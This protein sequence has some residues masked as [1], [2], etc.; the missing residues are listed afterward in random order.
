M[1][2][3]IAIIG[4]GGHGKVA[5]DTAEA[6]GYTE[7]VFL[8]QK[9]GERSRNGHWPIIGL[10][11]LSKDRTCFL[12]IGNNSTRERLCKELDFATLPS[13]V[14][15]TAIVSRYAKLERGVL[16]VAGSVINVDVFIGECSIINT[17]AT[18]DHDC[19][20]GAFVHI[21]PGANIAGGVSVGDRSWI[22]A[23]AVVKENIKIGADALVGAGAVVINDVPDGS[24]VVGNPAKQRIGSK[25]C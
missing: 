14:H 13:L 1:V 11:E 6:A 5:A 9:Y 17:S 16:L 21:S 23:G 3:D 24:T 22:G 18:V 2:K 8:D 20:I 7:I 19:T 4:A 10:P 25:K 15:P 12:A